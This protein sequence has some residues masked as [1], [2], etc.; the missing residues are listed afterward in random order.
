MTA[1]TVAAGAGVKILRAG[2]APQFKRLGDIFTE[3][4]LQLVHLFLRVE[5]TLRHRIAHKRLAML[6]EVGDL[7]IAQRRAEL[8]LLLERLA[9]GHQRVVLRLRAIIS[10]KGVDPLPHRL[11]VG[12]IQQGLAKFS[13]FLNDGAFF[14]NGLH[15]FFDQMVDA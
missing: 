8:L 6:F 10:H 1:A 5:E 12:L 9:F 7:L 13:R 14:G 11:N 2:H 3:G 4:L 15:N